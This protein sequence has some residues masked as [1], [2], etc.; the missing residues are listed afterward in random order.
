MI[1]VL[2]L[3]NILKLF[4]K[5]P[6]GRRAKNAFLQHCKNY[7]LERKRMEQ[8]QIAN[9]E[10]KNPQ[11]AIYHGQIMSIFALL[12]L[13]PGA[14]KKCPAYSKD[15]VGD[16]VMKWFAINGSVDSS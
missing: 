7:Y 4:P 9:Q 8:D 12:R 11:R 3:S 5:T 13:V 2:T 6:E 1:R 10:T 16:A 14:E 15:Q